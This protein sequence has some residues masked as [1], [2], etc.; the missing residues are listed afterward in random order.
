MFFVV[1][2]ILTVLLR[3][4]FWVLLL[5][6]WAFFEKK[7]LRKKWL[8][9]IIF[10]L[11]FVCS[12]KVLVNEL[13]VLWEPG[14]NK[15]QHLPKVA[16]VLGGFANYDEDRKEVVMT[17]AAERLYRAIELYRKGSIQTIVISG[18]A[19]AI[20]GKL[21]PESIYAK[22]Y[23]LQQ[24]IDSAAIVIDTLSKNTFENAL[25][26]KLLL[27]KMN[28]KG[29]VLLITTAS[30]MRRAKGC[31][32]KAGINTIPHSVQFFGAPARGYILSDYFIP[33][34]E[35]LRKFDALMK[36]WVGFV[37]YRITGKC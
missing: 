15:K 34:S 36:E 26:T 25:Q 6:A 13:A 23:L 12:N 10:F 18:G 1:S 22:Q 8:L 3:P 7:P 20:T 28:H 31:F 2:K 5:A 14:T 27:D 9:G 21:R 4:L 17:E 29:D 30:H 16:V 33:S 19:A 11:V 32:K 35:A 37:V 24:G